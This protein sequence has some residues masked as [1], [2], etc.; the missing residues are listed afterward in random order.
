MLHFRRE[1]T[2]GYFLLPINHFL[3]STCQF[4]T[5]EASN[6]CCLGLDLGLFTKPPRSGFLW[7]G[8]IKPLGYILVHTIE[9]GFEGR[10]LEFT[11]VPFFPMLWFCAFST[12][13]ENLNASHAKAPQMHQ[14]TGHSSLSSLPCSE[15]FCFF[16]LGKLGYV[17]RSLSVPSFDVIVHD[18]LSEEDR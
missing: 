10:S 8:G 18:I 5:L 16:E 12:P 3:S 2:I 4:I 11:S 7:T 9:L 1:H 14:E 13:K 15:S 6:I 17:L